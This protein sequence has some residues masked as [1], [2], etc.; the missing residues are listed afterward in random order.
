MV[1]L[2]VGPSGVG[3]S[4][5]GR[6]ACEGLPNCEFY[7]LDDLI[8]KNNAGESASSV[9]KRLGA[10]GFFDQSR[11]AIL[12]VEANCIDQVCVVAVGAGTLQ[13]PQCREF[14][15]KFPTISIWAPPE[16]V[17]CRNP[18]G[19][20]REITEYKSTEYSTYRERIYKDSRF[21]FPVSGLD[22][23]TAKQKFAEFLIRGVLSTLSG[24]SQEAAD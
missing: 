15:E 1:V 6:F 14:L 24:P 3:K 20:G 8:K 13:S 17:L 18:L 19:R 7:D 5:L 23:T 16:E 2:L 4:S 22:E 12:Q 9:L 21:Q 10:D 11:R